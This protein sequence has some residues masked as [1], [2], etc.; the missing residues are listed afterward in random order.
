[1]GLMKPSAYMSAWAMGYWNDAP[2]RP[3][4]AS[5]WHVPFGYDVENAK[6]YLVHFESETDR[7][8]FVDL[9]KDDD[10]MASIA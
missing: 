3:F 9:H 6:S 2:D 5:F 10:S 8:T 7:D 4:K 1:M